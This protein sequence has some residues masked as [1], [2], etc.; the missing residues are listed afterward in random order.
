MTEETERLVLA[1]LVHD[2]GKHIARTARN[3]RGDGVPAA[4]LPLLCADLYRIDGGRRASDV[5]HSLRTE[6]GDAHRAELDRVAVLLEAID[7]LE[8][9]V[10]RGEPEASIR[11]VSLACE[12]ER[13]LRALLTPR[14]DP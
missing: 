1:A 7:R 14:G 8:A 9:E 4:L 10:V 11:V 13:S 6:L 2:V 3:V 5:F 12:V